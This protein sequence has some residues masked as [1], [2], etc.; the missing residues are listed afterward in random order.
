M[1]N[2]VVTCDN[3][4]ATNTYVRSDVDIY[5]NYFNTNILLLLLCVFKWV[6]VNF[7]L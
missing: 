2:A 7:F 6:A 3:N 4:H 1:Q 5:Y